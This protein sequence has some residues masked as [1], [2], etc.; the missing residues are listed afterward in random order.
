MEKTQSLI[1]TRPRK[2]R[3]VLV[4]VDSK[5]SIYNIEDSL[6]ELGELAKTAGAKPIAKISQS[7]DHIHPSHY[8]GKG[9][10]QEVKQLLQETQADGIICDDELSPVQLKNLEAFL[11]TKIMDRTMLIMDIFAQRAVSREGNLQVELAQLQY[12]LPRL[13]GLGTSLSRLGGGIGTRG[14]GE[15]KLESDRRHIRSRIQELKKELQNLEKH[16]ELIRSRRQN[17]GTPLIGIIG[18]TNAGK[19]TL[20]N[21]LTEAGV[22]AEDKLFA[23]L[24]PTTRKVELPGGTEVLFSDTVGFIHKLP[25]HLIQAFRSTLEEV[26]YADI[27]LHVVNSQSLNLEHQMQIVYDTLKQIGDITCP[28]ITV[29][30]KIDIPTQQPLLPDPRAKRTYPISAEEKIG[31]TEL[32]QG[33]EE[34]LQEDKKLF[35]VFIPYAESQWVQLIYGQCEVIK[36]EH[37]AEGTYMKVYADNYIIHKLQK[38][39]TFE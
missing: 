26:H 34:V 10:I 19:S 6:E 20:L 29:Y 1:E 12:R 24:D 39:E 3:V 28:I 32:L 2:E 18:Y 14:P 25:H 16:R 7:L 4:G 15:T 27:L 5:Q 11:D 9:K 38:Y 21:A 36:I 22:L 8:I 37:R 30:N 31:L 17:S 23:T 33:I 13:V 35:E